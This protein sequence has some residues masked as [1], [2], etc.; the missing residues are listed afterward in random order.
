M[1]QRFTL[2]LSAAVVLASWLVCGL[3]YAS[4]PPEQSDFIPLF[5]I[6]AAML[7]LV[8]AAVVVAG[9]DALTG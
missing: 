3:S 6:S 7:T 2:V 5:V 8:A 4:V 1:S 9:A